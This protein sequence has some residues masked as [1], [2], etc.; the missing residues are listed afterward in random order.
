MK[1]PITHGGVD[2][3]YK[4]CQC[5]E[6]KVVAECTPLFDFYTTDEEDS[7]PLICER[8]L[9]GFMVRKDQEKRARN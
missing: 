4:L 2:R 5:H 1:K 8:C 6:C 9:M 3:G 7:G